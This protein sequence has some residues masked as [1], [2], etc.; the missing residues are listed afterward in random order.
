MRPARPSSRSFRN[1]AALVGVF[2]L[3]VVAAPLHAQNA[4]PKVPYRPRANAIPDPR[5][6]RGQQPLLAIHAAH[7][8]KT[9]Y[10]RVI[11]PGLK[12]SIANG[13]VQPVHAMRGALASPRDGI[14]TTPNFGGYVSAPKFQAFDV[15]DGD[16]SGLAVF[17]SGDFNKDGKPDIATVQPSGVVNVILN[18]GPGGNSGTGVSFGKPITTKPGSVYVG[19]AQQAIAAD[20]NGDGYADLIL[21]DSGN[22][23]IDVLINNGDAT[24]ADP[25]QV[26][27]ESANQLNAF[28]MGDINGDGK[29][30]ILLLSSNVTYDAN[31]NATTTLQFDTYLNNGAGFTPPTGPLTQKQ[32]YADYYQGLTGCSIV[33]ADVD[34]DGK[35]DATVELIHW[36]ATITPD[37]DHVVLTMKG[38]GTGAFA[39]PDP[40]ATIVLPSA[41]TFNI[42]YPLVANLNVIDINDDG[43]KDV[44]WSWQD[45]S[46]WAALGNG[47][48]TYQYPY[49]VGASMAYPTDLSVVD[50]N[51]D[52][53]PDLVDAEPDYLA[54]YPA[55]G[56]GTFDLPTIRNYG[57]G[58]GQFSVLTVADFN[59]DGLPDAAV[60]NSGEGSVTVF[61]SNSASV[62]SLFAGPL[63]ASGSDVISRVQAQTVLD[64]NGDGIDDIFF[65]SMGAALDN[66]RLVTALGDGKGGFLN[67]NAVPGFD[68]LN[69]DF[70][71][72]ATGDFNGDGLNDMVVHTEAGVWLM[73]SNGDGTFTPNAITLAEGFNCS[74]NYAAV[75]DLDGDGKLDL[76]VAY[77]GDPIYGCNSGA[78]PSG[79]F[80]LLG[81]GDGTFKPA[82]FTAIGEEVFQPVL[83][84]LNG[85]GHLDLEL[86]DVPYDV[87]GGVFN[88]YVL[89]GKGDG[90]FGQPATVAANFIN[91]STLAGD[92]NG[93][94]FTDLVMLSQGLTDPTQGTIDLSQA[95]AIVFLGDGNGGMTQ[96]ATFAPGYF[97]PGGVLEDLNGDAKLDLLLSEYSSVDFTNGLAGGVAGIGNGDGTFTAVG[98]YEVGD[99]STSVLA[100]SF[101]KDNAPDAAF[102][103][104]GSGTTILI[105]KGG[106][107][108]TLTASADSIPVGGTANFTFTLAPTLAGQPT[109]GG[110]VTL[111]EGTTTLGGGTLNAGSVAIPVTG[112][113]AGS[114]LVAA[115]YGGDANFNWN[116]SATAMVNVTAGSSITL[117]S[118]S[119]SLTLA[120]NQTGV[121][122]ETVTA[123]S[124][125]SGNV[126]LSVSGVPSGVAVAINPSAVTL[127]GGGSASAS[128][129]ISTNAISS[130]GV[131]GG[132]EGG[133]GSVRPA[134]MMRAMVRA[135]VWLSVIAAMAMWFA[136]RRRDMT[137]V[138]VRVAGVV[139]V[140]AAILAQAACGGGSGGGYKGAFTLTITAQPADSSVPA[141]TT[142]VDVT[143]N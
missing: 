50:I 135:M 5:L 120:K 56:D 15:A 47:D 111:V 93:D 51:G 11:E 130:F 106:T 84:D 119:P 100:G 25:V 89:V 22:N 66:P 40:N 105:A 77:E 121:V 69:F 103:S 128:L 74:T 127:Q 70:A 39:Q 67:K 88:S 87:P 57:S 104:G 12:R 124:A 141:Q 90:T 63:L 2:V 136:S 10:E 98:N 83:V 68:T 117:T 118:S 65:Y 52:G 34:G 29:P 91:A 14:A 116:A 86:S 23:C 45:Y 107:K 24:F 55:N 13:K 35:A 131:P 92:V 110:S 78:T 30:D 123:S 79:F 16:T 43:V 134:A 72:A 95:G 143:I 46:I 99:S 132:S 101:L 20:V 122:T 8:P 81:N 32:T 112:L 28:A 129:V 18:Q 80:T 36:L 114:H 59:G 133:S 125:F 94:G 31:F 58:M 17:A 108:A 53:K 26:A 139:L 37:I 60:M 137:R 7:T 64:A 61:P 140:S 76:V 115:V 113:A 44:V 109:P 49:N 3:F 9:P 102:V 82:T 19:G 1:V 97:S 27:E 73:V 48:G 33:L 71:D 75:G 126:T 142:T 41:S 4:S 21:L 138:L 38:A 96:G 62:P 6:S 85:D 54:I 42:G